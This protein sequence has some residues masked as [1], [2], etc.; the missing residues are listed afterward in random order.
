M[1]LLNAS[2]SFCSIFFFL[3]KSDE[4][5]NSAIQMIWMLNIAYLDAR[6]SWME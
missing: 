6:N 5:Q 2:L 4:I 1:I 3:K